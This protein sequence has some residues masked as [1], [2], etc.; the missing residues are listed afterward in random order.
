MIWISVLISVLV[1]ALGVC[2]YIIFNLYRKYAMLESTA[3]DNQEFILA[4]RNRVMNQRSYLRQ[5]DKIGSFEADDEVGFFFTELKKIIADISSYFDME[6][7]IES[8]GA[9]VNIPTTQPNRVL[10]ERLN[11]NGTGQ[12]E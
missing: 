10:I 11:N 8:D 7:E 4:L 6:Y 1:I 5:L 2:G 3:I 9:Q 12:Q